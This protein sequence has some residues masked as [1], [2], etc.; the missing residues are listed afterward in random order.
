MPCQLSDTNAR[1]SLR[2][3]AA[4]KGLEIY[5]KY[6]PHIGW[7]ELGQ[8]LEDRKW[9]RY[10]CQIVFDA[11]PLRPG[12]FAYP[13]PKGNLPE[14]GFAIYVHP[15][16]RT[17]LNRVPG[18]VLYQLV[19]VNYGGFA[20]AEDAETFGACALGIDREQYYRILCGIADELAGDPGTHPAENTA[21]NT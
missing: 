12:E 16:L 6:G 4:E 7:N 18:V 9:V 21:E 20:S 13:A 3:H 15:C 2:D 5:A 1:Q 11:G 14:D 19:A 8:I 10:P 17:Q